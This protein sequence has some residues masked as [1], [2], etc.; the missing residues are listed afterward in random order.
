MNDESEL[1]MPEPQ[2]DHDPPRAPGGPD[3]VPEESDAGEG[4]HPAGL[5]VTPDPPLSAQ[6]DETDVP[7]EIQEPDGAD[8]ASTDGTLPEADEPD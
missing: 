4:A 7:D 5:L 2:A 6:T 3:A 8:D 1:G